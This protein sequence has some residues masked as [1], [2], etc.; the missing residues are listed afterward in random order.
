MADAFASAAAKKGFPHIIRPSGDPVKPSYSV[1]RRFFRGPEQQ[2]P[3][4]QIGPGIFA[5]NESAGY[6]WQ[7]YKKHALE[8]SSLLMSSYPNLHSFPWQPTLLELRYIDSIGAEYISHQDLVRFVNESTPLRVQMPQFFSTNGFGTTESAQFVFTF[9]VKGKRNTTFAMILGNAMISGVKTIMLQ[10][11]VVTKGDGIQIGKSL[12]EQRN[13]LAGWLEDSHKLT[14]QF[15]KSFI[16][17]S[18]MERFR[19]PRAKS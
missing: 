7:A 8:G 9:P 15:F 2:F 19:S 3:I 16:G 1:E 5:A 6:E 12:A 14:S 11:K 13:Y 17:D 10:S 18:L 4:W